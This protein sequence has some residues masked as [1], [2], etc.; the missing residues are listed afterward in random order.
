[1]THA[2]SRT[3]VFPRAGQRRRV[4]PPRTETGTP[5]TRPVPNGSLRQVKRIGLAILALKLAGFCVWSGL[6]YQRFSLTP[7]FAQYQQA[8][9][10]I[11]HGNLNPYDTVG[12]FAFWQNHGEFIMWP[13]ALLYW[14]LPGGAG[15]LWMQDAGVIGAEVVA[16]LWA[17]QLAQK[18]RPGRDAA[19]LAAAGLVL[20]VIN[21]W[22]WWSVSFDFHAECLAVLFIALL[23]WDLA[24]GRRR[25]W[26]W[27]PLLVACGDVAGTYIF[28]LGLGLALA[29]RGQRIR[30]VV[31]AGL[32]IFAVLGISAIHG[33]LGS[34]HGLQAYDYLAAPGYSGSLT[35]TQL[36]TGLATHPV[37]VLA[38]MWSK[39]VDIWANLGA[40]GLL[41]VAFLPLMPIMAVILVSN[42]LFRGFL[43][44]E[45]LFQS[46]PIY[47]LLPAGTVAVLAW[48]ARR[49]RKTAL[50]VT[51]LLVVQAIGWSAVWS[52]RT[53]PQWERVP[54][55]TAA[56][57]AAVLK[58][59]P[60][61]DAVFASQGVVGRF[62]ERRDVRPMNGHLP[63]Q[64]GHDWF[65]F[66][67]WVG[68]ETQKP[69]AAMVFAGQLAGPMHARLLLDKNGVWVFRWTPPPGVHRLTV[70]AGA[71]PL[72]AWTA[73]G[74]AG[75]AVLSGAPSS[76]HVTS[77]GQRG[78]VADRLEWARLTGQFQALVTLSSTA[79]VNV[80]VWDN[81]GNVL[82]T[83]ESLPSTDG[84]ETITLP[85]NAARDYRKPLYGG[86]GLFQAKFGGGP[87]G[88]RLEVRVWTP[89]GGTVNVYAAQLK[90]LS[91]S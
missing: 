74:A 14:V 79:P 22:S 86:W 91:H 19:W 90:T 68:I 34:G 60:P 17:C 9:Y 82:L 46:L 42:D 18:Y 32:G 30:G 54:A 61:Q 57:L 38:K 85:V 66:T 47:V 7:D 59:I 26:L 2:S 77:T 65:V 80:E 1:V 52:P 8:W 84:K 41:G 33:N 71:T 15:L 24:N 23:A 53:V 4:P 56:T 12:N 6:L 73:P 87:K 69:A 48:L 35:L 25:A 81:T 44:S 13:L 28:G 72:P 5:G 31:V 11:A 36:L 58:Q 3:S 20:L 40:S 70:P 67:P 78:Y 16:F 76:W 83:R 27:I 51:A 55:S 29:V 64:Q 45:P 89:G 37:A 50:V 39:R 10:L 62:S 49:W 63:I 43:F 21:P 88:E 75:R